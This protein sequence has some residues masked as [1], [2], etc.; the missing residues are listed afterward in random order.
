MDQSHQLT[1]YIQQCLNQGIPLSDISNQLLQQ[2]WS[3]ANVDEAFRAVQ[4][5]YS[6]PPA[7]GNQPTQLA[8]K[9]HRVRN[10]V[11]WIVSPYIILVLAAILEL[12]TRSIGNS[13]I[14]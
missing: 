4:S 2:G 13:R 11:L 9:P 3:Q 6:Q 8:A 7:I 12:L 10:G 14:I 5:S 1:N